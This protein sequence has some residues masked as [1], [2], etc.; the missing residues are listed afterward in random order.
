[1]ADTTTI[2]TEE[3]NSGIFASLFIQSNQKRGLHQS[4]KNSSTNLF[5]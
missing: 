5:E 4:E 1:M 2:I 3:G